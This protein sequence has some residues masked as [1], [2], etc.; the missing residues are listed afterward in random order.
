[1]SH[2]QTNAYIPPSDDEREFLDVEAPFIE[3]DPSSDRHWYDSKHDIFFTCYLFITIITTIWPWIFF[4]VVWGKNGIEL[5]S[6]VVKNHQKD[7]LYVVTVISNIIGL[8]AAHLFSKAVVCL[9]QKR[10]VYKDT[11]IADITFFTALKNHSLKLS[12]LRQGRPHLFIMVILYPIVFSLITPG[13]TTFL[14]PTNFSRLYNLTGSELDFGSN[15][16]DCRAWFSNNYDAINGSSC[17]WRVSYRAT[18]PVFLLTL[19]RIYIIFVALVIPLVL[20]RISLW[21]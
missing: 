17:D 6:Q 9:A 19:R 18:L 1:M 2:E 10:V 12:L 11:D 13:F 4:W 8:T 21:T 5:S 20:W 14:T 7:T 3:T 15:D 16:P